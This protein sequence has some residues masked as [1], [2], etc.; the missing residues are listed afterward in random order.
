MKKQH[1]IFCFGC[2]L[3]ICGLHIP[4]EAQKV[5]PLHQSSR[6]KTTTAFPFYEDFSKVTGTPDTSRWEAGSGVYVNYTYGIEPPTIGVATFDG[7]DA[8]GTPYS[9]DAPS[10]LGE[11]DMLTSKA[12]DLSGFTIDDAL[13][14]TFYWQ[15]RG[16]G[17]QPNADDS[18]ILEFKDAQGEWVRQW[19]ASEDTITVFDQDTIAISQTA[20]LHDAFQFRFVSYGRLSGPYD[21]WNID[22]IYFNTLQ[23]LDRPNTGIVRDLGF[24]NRLPNL[25]KGYSHLPWKAFRAWQNNVDTLYAPL[26]NVRSS[27]AGDNTTH[28]F[29][30]RIYEN[31]V[32]VHDETIP[33]SSVNRAGLASS[34]G[35]I[36]LFEGETVMVEAPVSL[37][38]NGIAEEAGVRI[39][40]EFFLFEN[41]ED[42]N[43]VATE[44]N[45]TLRV[46]TSLDKTF[47]YDD[48]SAELGWGVNKKFGKFAVEFETPVDWEMDAVQIHVARVG[49][50][51]TQ[52]GF[53]IGVWQ[54]IDTLDSSNDV[55]LSPLKYYPISYTDSINEFEIFQ[56]QSKITVPAGKF[57][58]VLEQLTDELLPIGFDVQT[59]RSEKLFV[60]LGDAR[61]NQNNQ[62]IGSLMI[63]PV[64]AAPVVTGNESVYEIEGLT[65]YPNPSSGKVHWN[66]AV[67]WAAV[68]DATGRTVMH[69]EGGNEQS[70]D[71]SGYPVGIYF[72]QFY[73]E[74]AISVKKV[75]KY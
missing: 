11:A 50:K 68:K 18:L 32:L 31:E 27:S 73:K 71:L 55:I 65:V 64:E 56:L 22:Y 53:R 20:F 26:S 67:A 51:L 75:V 37:P 46:I 25:L 60:N 43:V 12:M 3:I 40:Q 33:A 54:L 52:G 58:V 45:D 72:L 74:G 21:T 59:D 24:S 38:T 2:L 19:G 4:A 28:L 48:G 16:W 7:L 44:Q 47:A 70:I 8:A 66:K 49:R 42:L 29:A 35:T 34:N 15:A 17:E 30:T 39:E 14:L 63:R 69:W 9:F 1:L 57:Y 13:T 5:V 41:A 10:D 6:L 62:F 61:W 23:N 36:F